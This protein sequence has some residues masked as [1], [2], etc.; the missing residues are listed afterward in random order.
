MSNKCLV[1]VSPLLL[2]RVG[3]AAQ[4]IDVGSLIVQFAGRCVTYNDAT[5]WNVTHA[6]LSN[7]LAVS[8][9]EMRLK[10][11]EQVDA[12]MQVNQLVHIGWLRQAS[13][14]CPL[15]SLD[16]DTQRV[17]E[18]HLPDAFA[19]LLDLPEGNQAQMGAE[20]MVY[21]YCL[22][23]SG[24]PGFHGASGDAFVAAQ[25]V[26]L[27][28]SIPFDVVKVSLPSSHGDCGE[29]ALPHLRPACQPGSLANSNGIR[30]G[31]SDETTN[32]DVIFAEAPPS[33]A[34]SAD[35]LMSMS[36]L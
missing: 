29:G 23:H 33:Q 11:N 13:K 34:V 32:T 21:F 6:I 30:S 1:R 16:L 10:R 20:P 27:D 12:V 18:R 17:Y 5:E 36:V 24:H 4:K 3:E 26:V 2:G 28:S 25:H 8:S 7:S 14:S 35:D 19:A 22:A 9:P 15:S 31:N